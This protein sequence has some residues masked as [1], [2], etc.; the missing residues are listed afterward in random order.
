M[1]WERPRL[2]TVYP[3]QDIQ[4]QELTPAMCARCSKLNTSVRGRVTTTKVT[5]NKIPQPY[6]HLDTLR[7]RSPSTD[8][9]LDS[10][11][12]VP[13][14]SIGPCPSPFPTSR[15]PNP[16]TSP[17]SCMVPRRRLLPPVA[18]PLRVLLVFLLLLAHR[19]PSSDLIHYLEMDIT[20][21][22]LEVE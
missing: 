20:F 8:R 1:L 11:L 14:G 7:R 16:S 19:T 21:A 12:L 6:P 3:F 10:Q 15:F 13:L 4:P 2:E 17:T 5:R 9:K 22:K 18:R